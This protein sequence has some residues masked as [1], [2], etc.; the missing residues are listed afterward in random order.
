MFYIGLKLKERE[1]IIKTCPV[2]FGVENITK[3]M[4]VYVIW[5]LYSLDIIISI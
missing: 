5:K 1:T 3:L 4:N 2:R